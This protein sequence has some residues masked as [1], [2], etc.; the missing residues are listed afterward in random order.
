MA[1]GRV[2]RERPADRHR[3][4]TFVAHFTKV[5]NGL[6]T[7]I[8]AYNDAAGSLQSSVRPQAVRMRDHSLAVNKELDDPN[9][10]EVEPR[11]IDWR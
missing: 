5:G 3:L 2:G 8:N 7:A 10:V 4:A 9:P 11:T 1:A 6:R